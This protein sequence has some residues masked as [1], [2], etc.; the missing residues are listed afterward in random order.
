MGNIGGNHYPERMSARDVLT[1]GTATLSALLAL[2]SAGYV[3]RATRRTSRELEVLKVSLARE[4][5]EEQSRREYEYAA[6]KR[7]YDEAEPLIIKLADSCDFAASRIIDL[8]DGRRWPELRATRDIN[9]FWM[10]SRS[11]EVISLARALL[12]PLALHTLLT[13]KLTLVDLSYDQRVSEIYTLARAAYQVH[14]DDYVIAAIDPALRYDPVVPGWRQKRAA[15]P[16][17]YWWQ[18]LTRGRLDPA[19]ELCIHRD[20]GRLTTR[21]EFES[22]YLEL[23]ASPGDSRVKSLGLFCNPL[24]NFRPQDRPTYWRMLMCQLLIYRRISLRSRLP[25][26]VPTSSQFDFDRRDV[27]ALQRFGGVGDAL[28]DVSLTAALRYVGE[29]WIRQWRSEA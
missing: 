7:I 8:A 17:T 27:D 20:A 26:N 13:E 18:G 1:A 23:Y 2:V 25:A 21:E 15:D 6:R 11:S 5:A 10:L 4:S 19:I 16:A 28:L 9:A 3:S 14:L 12:E 22:R 24:Y 29:S